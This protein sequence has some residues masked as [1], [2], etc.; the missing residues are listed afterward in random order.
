MKNA[1]GRGV[2]RMGDKTS[3]GGQVISAS[4]SLKALGKAVALEGDMVV[5]PQCKGKFPIIV[6]DSDRKHH[7]KRVAHQGDKAACGAILCSSI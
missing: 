4:D 2:I 3:H 6:S 5:C 1:N 7:G